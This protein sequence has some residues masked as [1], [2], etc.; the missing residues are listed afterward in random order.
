MKDYLTEILIVIAYSGRTQVAIILGMI[1]LIVI[2]LVDD[3][4][5]AH[6]RLTGPMAGLTDVIRE[7]FA[8][9]YHG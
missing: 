4:S 2:N 7:K 9:R 3:Y 6:F 8:H 5:L 1:G